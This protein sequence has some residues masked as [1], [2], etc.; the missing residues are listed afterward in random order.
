M[1]DT[2]TSARIP[3]LDGWRALSILLVLAGQ[4]LPLGRAEWRMN[5]SVAASGMALFFCL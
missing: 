2:K 3:I 1:S 4:W 5:E